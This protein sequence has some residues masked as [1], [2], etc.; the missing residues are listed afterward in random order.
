MLP[1][2]LPCA[3]VFSLSLPDTGEVDSTG[4]LA[5]Q[6]ILEEMAG[7]TDGAELLD[8]LAWR[9]EH[10][11][12]L[13]RASA[14]GL[15]SIPGV[16]EEDARA[17]VEHRE[18]A[19][20]FGS[21]MQLQTMPRGSA[22]LYRILSPYVTVRARGAPARTMA[23]RTRVMYR[24]RTGGMVT[25]DPAGT[26]TRVTL[27]PVDGIE[28]GG[29]FEKAAGESMAE[30]FN[31]GYGVVRPPW[32]EWEFILGDYALR[33][34]EGLV[35]WNGGFNAKSAMTANPPGKSGGGFLPH[36]AGESNRSFRGAAATS[37]FLALGGRWRASVFVSRRVLA[38]HVDGEGRATSILEPGEAA[39]AGGNPAISR[40]TLDA[41]GGRLEFTKDEM[42][43][44][45][46]TIMRAGFDRVLLREDPFRFSGREFGARGLDLRL[47][48]RRATL[49]A[50]T[51]WNDAGAP[52]WIAGARVSPVSALSL[53]F[54]YRSY[55]PGYDNMMAAGFGENGSTRNERG[56][57]AG[58]F[59][60][61]HPACTL[62]GYVDLFRHPAP[63]FLAPFAA[64]GEEYLFTA[65]VRLT[66]AT[67]LR[68]RVSRRA[69]ETRVPA[70][71][72]WGRTIDLVSL[73]RKTR[74]Q[75]GIEFSPGGGWELQS[76]LEWLQSAPPGGPV[77]N[78]VGI[79]HVVRGRVRPFLRFEARGTMFSADAYASRLSVIENDLPGVFGGQTFFGRGVRWYLLI[80]IDPLPWCSVMV[81]IS[82]T[83]KEGEISTE[84]RPVEVP[85]TRD[86]RAGAQLDLRW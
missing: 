51:A 68:A 13:N 64:R 22:R 79:S 84:G 42:V 36:R 30:S 44:L 27:Q 41:A 17:I 86:L 59:F 47:S 23:L 32:G 37:G 9:S 21:V 56:A 78:G 77:S 7:E 19:G 81:K 73:D 1:C 35:V 26:S 38:A 20:G 16:R 6:E 74:L 52:A 67:V 48:T 31:G 34:G 83:E 18:N 71:D 69:A 80:S 24:R 62:R 8:E 55:D 65:E 15:L 66:R 40:I 29:I 49:F 63:G 75:W 53:L 28:L 57:Y 10:P 58:F 70:G 76:R 2:L 5:A 39:G 12:N 14:A 3:L 61:P 85:P 25:S 4:F 45:G 82:A 60:E 43:F 72:P 54:L 50:E 46:G 33:A 11:L